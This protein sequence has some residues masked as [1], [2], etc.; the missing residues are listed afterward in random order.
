MLSHFVQIRT[1]RDIVRQPPLTTIVNEW[2]NPHSSIE[3]REHQ[4][5][6]LKDDFCPL[7]R[8]PGGG[9]SRIRPVLS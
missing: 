4:T 2:R 5:G 6:S 7:L 3:G 1:R 9:T 8:P